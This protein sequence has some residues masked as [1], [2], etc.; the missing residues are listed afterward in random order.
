[1]RNMQRVIFLLLLSLCSVYA[2]GKKSDEVTIR[3]HAEAKPE[4]GDTFSAAITLINPPKQIRIDQVPIINERDITAFY[5]FAAPDGSIACYFQL[6]A[7]GSHK[8]EQHTTEY[9]DTLV[10][11][12]INGRVACAME[13]DK[14]ITDGVLLISSGF[15]P[16]EIAQMQLKYPTIGNEKNFNDQK[17]KAAMILKEVNKNKPKATPAPKAVPN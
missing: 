17:K 4:D 5:P 6:D 10:V 14:K 15:L 13:V 9:R 1:M 8:L 7:E 12:L 3:L 11:A 2:G 16:V